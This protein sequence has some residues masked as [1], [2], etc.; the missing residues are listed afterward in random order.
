M[1][2]ISGPSGHVWLPQGSCTRSGRVKRRATPTERMTARVFRKAALDVPAQD[3]RTIEV[4]AQGL[5][6]HDGVQLAVDITMRSTRSCDLLLQAAA[7]S[8]F[9]PLRRAE[10]GARRLC[11][12]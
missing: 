12:R 9:S 7:S 3:S 6:C 4:L 11:P 2:R 8:W 10:D 1:R 5:P